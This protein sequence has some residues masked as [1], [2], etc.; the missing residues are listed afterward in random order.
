MPNTLKAE[1]L[2]E[3]STTSGTFVDIPSTTLTFTPATTGEVW[4]VFATGKIR[5]S[6]SSEQTVEIRLVINGT[7]HDLCGHQNNNATAP[8]GAGFLMFDRI[9]GVATLQ[10]VKLQFRAITGTSYANTLRVVVAKVPSGADFQYFESNA[11]TVSNGTDLNV[12]QLQFNPSADGDYVIVAK[13]SHREDPGG[14]TSQAWLEDAGATIPLRPDA[15]AGTRHSNAREPWNPMSVVF[16]TPLTTAVQTFIL[17][18]TSSNGN[19][20]PACCCCCG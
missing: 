12:G 9:T 11:I 14:S 6:S 8:N 1:Q 20:D 3:Q 19:Q 16:S 17:R 4:M 10:T 13:M 18:F 15:P 2:S 7:E 5:S